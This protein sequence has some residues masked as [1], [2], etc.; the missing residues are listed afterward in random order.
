MEEKV[1]KFREGFAWDIEPEIVGKEIEKISSQHDGK[2]TPKLTVEEAKDP[3]NPLHKLFDWNNKTAGHK[4]RLQQARNLIGSL[5]IDIVIKDPE[6]VRAFIN[7]NIK[8]QGNVY[9][10]FSDVVND[11]EKLNLII[12]EERRKLRAISNRLRIYER[13]RGL[14]I[15]IDELV[16]EEQWG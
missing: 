8:D 13:F 10:S 9:C 6:E 16:L 14:A 11:D 1:F 7:L 12:E 5:V 15:K 3:D 4:W 2:I